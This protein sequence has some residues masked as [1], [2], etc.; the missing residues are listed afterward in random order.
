MASVV[1]VGAGVVGCCAADLLRRELPA[2]AQVTL[3]ASD[4]ASDTTSYGAAGIFRMNEGGL[5][6]P[7]RLHRWLARSFDH[8]LALARSQRAPTIGAN[9]VKLYQ[10][11][12]T[13]HFKRPLYTSLCFDYREVSSKELRALQLPESCQSGCLV[14]TVMVE[15]RLFVPHLL[16]SF[17]NRGGTVLQGKVAAWADLADFD[18][19]V[20]CAGAGARKLC[21]DDLVYPV[22][23]QVVRVKAPW[24]RHAI[25]LNN[26]DT[27]IYPGVES[28][29]LGGIRQPGSWSTAVLQEDTE[30]VLQRSLALEPSLQLAKIEEIWAGVRPCRDQLRL[31]LD[32]QSGPVPIVHNYGHGGHGVMLAHGTA[33]E[34]VELTKIA[35]K[36]RKHK[37]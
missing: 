25:N 17:R 6:E 7:E 16:T 28:V 30:T 10:L 13:P 15:P 20:N 8:Y 29:T 36:S 35:L 4:F 33:E 37:L 27:Y 19:I 12:D 9:L 14:S 34:V 2:S 5:A 11:F 23:G 32:L 1:V 21:N 31:E 22:R 18:V 26:P 3:I 24:L